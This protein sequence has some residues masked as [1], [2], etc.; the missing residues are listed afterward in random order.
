[1]VLEIGEANQ[2]VLT[3]V[4]SCGEVSHLATDIC[5]QYNSYFLPVCHKDVFFW[6]PL[7]IA[8]NAI[9]K[10]RLLLINSSASFLCYDFTDNQTSGFLYRID[11]LSCAL[12]L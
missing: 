10:L 11:P 9:A 4:G 7:R 5:V 6:V 1:M 2:N 12:V 3:T 8:S